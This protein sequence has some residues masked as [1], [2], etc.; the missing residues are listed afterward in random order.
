MNNLK[1]F[2]KLLV[3]S[4]IFTAVLVIIGLYGIYN[5]KSTFDW[6]GEVYENAGTIDRLEQEIVRP[7]AQLRQLSLSIVMAPDKKLQKTFNRERKAL[8]K[9]VDKMLQKWE[10]YIKHDVEM[11]IFHNLQTAWDQYKILTNLTVEKA[12]LGYRESAF[13]NAI[14]AERKQFDALYVQTSKWLSDQVNDTADVYAAARQ[15][16]NNMFWISLGLIGIAA[17][18]VFLFSIYVAR[19]IVNPLTQVSQHLKILAEGKLAKEVITYKGHDEIAEIV[20]STVQ[21]KNAF[22]SIIDQA[23]A[24]AAGDYS[25]NVKLL[26]DEDQLGLALAEMTETLRGVIQQA[27]A[28]ANGDYTQK[29]KLLSEQDQL[30][31]ALSEMTSTLLE[32]TAKAAAQDWLKTGQTQLSEKMSGEQDIVALSN[33]IITFLIH[34]IDAQVGTFYIASTAESNAQ[35]MRLK[36]L[37]SYAYTKRKSLT[38][39]FIVGEGIVGQAALEKENIII[40]G[41]PED[42]M[43]IQSSLGKAQPRNLLVMPFLYEQE[44]KGVIELGSFNE[45]TDIQLD[46]LNQVMP[47]I[48]I[49][50]NTAKSR[51]RLQTLLH[52]SQHQSEE[53]QSQSEELQTQQEELRQTNEELIG[54]TQDLE[55]QQRDIHQKN[56]ELGKSQQTIEAKA[57]ELELASKYKSEFLANMSH[58]LRTPLNSLLILAQLLCNNK[59]G[60]LNEKQIEYAKTIHNAGGELLTLIN[61][62]LDLSKVEA[63]KV[64]LNIEKMAM[65]KL[66]D[67]IQEKFQPLAKDKQL[68]FK[69]EVA[70]NVPTTLYT[71]HQRLQQIII[72]F[73]SNA[74]KFTEEG[75]VELSICRPSTNQNLSLSGLNPEKTIAF[76]VI[77]S[78]VG[79]PKEKQRSIFEAFHQ[80]DG[81][82]SRRYGGTG[83]GLSISREFVRLFGGELQLQ[84]EKGKGSTFTFFMP[85]NIGE[86]KPPS[87]P[88]FPQKSTDSTTIP[89]PEKSDLFSTLVVPGTLKSSKPDIAAPSSEKS[90]TLIPVKM[91]TD[92]RASLKAVD[93]SLLIIDDD[94]KFLQILMEMAREKGFKCIVAM[95]GETG[96][97]LAVEYKPSAIILD[98]GMPKVDGWTVMDKLKD[99]PEIRHIPVYFV[100]G[101][102]KELEARSMGAIGYLLKPVNISELEQAF[103]KIE[104]FVTNTIKNL[105]LVT[106]NEQHQRIIL[107]LV[108]GQDVRTIVANTV[109][110]AE[111]H[112]RETPIDCLILDVDVEQGLG[113]EKLEQMY[114][115]ENLSQIPII[116]YV[117]RELT[118]DEEMLLQHCSE[119]MTIK[120]VN[121]PAR[122]LDEATLFL[123]QIETSLSKEK[124]NMLRMVHDKQLILAHK[125]VLLVDDDTRNTYALLLMLEEEE[126]QVTVAKNGKE[127]LEELEKKPDMDVVLMDIMMPEMDGYE[128]MQKI[129]EQ[130]QFKKLPI[131]AL[132]AKAMKGD[133]AKCIEA[134]ANDYLPKPINMDKLISL[135]RVWLYQ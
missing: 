73:L 124:R 55:Q 9:N 95:D 22:N 36:M 81:T 54:R 110:T 19:K 130:P 80:A 46:F 83:L 97:Q 70:T 50:V 96:L 75:S 43:P 134:G 82:T 84:S 98:I 100:S 1:I 120:S 106:D 32:V 34:Y 118:K 7:I 122:L 12:M 94:P 131:I 77:D 6:V 105:L 29:V 115:V 13:I 17:I 133:K 47:S 31:Q 40:T 128:A 56:L 42:Y 23:H 21:L 25:S 91:P 38:N 60:N 58:E 126:M 27:N 79:I 49:A 68:D 67:G 108:G 117:D 18:L 63:G 76:N 119:N 90:E 65:T 92:D 52:Q 114:Q 71:D 44:L 64:E 107:D 10:R 125:K 127:A 15:N 99:N 41:L 11:E 112:L 51:T 62:I 85:E 113:I 16:Y 109:E 103:K 102:D 26:S 87:P 74:F 37:A 123:H 28:I 20:A 24:I 93:K 66:V 59:E 116:V 39:E 53:L 86:Q 69:I 104:Y 101:Y 129:R 78:G 14:G 72:N 8:I 45:V 111:R 3:L 132:T 88:T 33:N 48:G 5:T 2:V 89:S 4:C 135:L 30:G 57:K 35:E 61:D 121:S